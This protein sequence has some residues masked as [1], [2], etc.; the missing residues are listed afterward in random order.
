MI[1]VIRH[2]QTDRNKEGRLQGRNGL[3]LNEA[4]LRQAWDL[5]HQ[6]SHINFDYVFS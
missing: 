1:Y 4:G 3:P 5:K 2:G 6:L